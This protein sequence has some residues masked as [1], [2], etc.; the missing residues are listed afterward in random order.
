[1]LLQNEQLNARKIGGVVL[2]VAGI[3][4]LLAR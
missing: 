4:L 3:V 1:M 2:T